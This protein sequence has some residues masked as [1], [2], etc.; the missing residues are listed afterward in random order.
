MHRDQYRFDSKFHF[1][2]RSITLP[3]FN[4]ANGGKKKVQKE[5]K[6]KRKEIEEKKQR[7]GIYQ[8]FFTIPRCNAR[9]WNEI[10]PFDVE[11]LRV[12]NTIHVGFETHVAAFSYRKKASIWILV[13][14]QWCFC[15]AW[16]N[17]NISISVADSTRVVV[18]RAC[19]TPVAH[20]K[21]D[22]NRPHRHFSLFSNTVCQ[23]YV[24]RSDES[25]I[26]RFW[27]K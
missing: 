6:E 3:R 2:V 27:G 20:D 24:S 9:Q 17:L 26:Y 21:R 23:L 5:W 18:Y 1:I 4:R 10:L 7:G 22:L 8:H 14:Y 19:E 15:H 11:M 25:S 13:A 16:S 12:H